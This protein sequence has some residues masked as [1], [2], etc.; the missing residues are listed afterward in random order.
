MTTETRKVPRYPT[1]WHRFDKRQMLIRYLWYVGVVFVAV[2]SV[3]NLDIPWFYFLDAHVHAGDLF[4]R[5]FPPD[6]SYWDVVVEPLFETI[7]I[8]TLGTLFSF[9]IAFPVAFISARN[10][11][12]NVA[13]WLK[14]S[15]LIATSRAF[16][17][18]I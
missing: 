10:T 16:I 17:A 14:S 8:A 13:A 3:R 2:W 1:V 6:W 7:H 11:T 5:M 9:A 18:S 12:P 15:K 4:A